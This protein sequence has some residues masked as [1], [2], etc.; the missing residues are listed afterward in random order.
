MWTILNVENIDNYFNEYPNLN[1][2]KDSYMLHKT[3]NKIMLPRFFYKNY[4]SF[5]LLWYIP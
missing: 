4:P 2:F 5:C 1:E 3:D